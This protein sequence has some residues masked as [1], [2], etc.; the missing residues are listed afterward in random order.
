[1]F[2]EKL[3]EDITIA[4]ITSP[5]LSTQTFASHALSGV[6]GGDSG[7]HASEGVTGSA[8]GGGRPGG[9]PGKQASGGVMGGGSGGVMGGP[10]TR[11]LPCHTPHISGG[12][13]GTM[14]PFSIGMSG[15]SRSSFEKAVENIDNMEKQKRKR[16]VSSDSRQDAHSR[17]HQGPYRQT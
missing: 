13:V 14:S 3:V 15:L 5:N 10:M 8:P 12:V 9:V 1:M 7:H 11:T 4:H 17:S 16:L 2:R 6:C